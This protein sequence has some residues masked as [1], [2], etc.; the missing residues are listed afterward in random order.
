MAPIAFRELAGEYVSHVQG[1][2][3]TG[4]MKMWLKRLLPRSIWSTMRAARHAATRLARQSIESLGFRLARRSDFYSPLPSEFELKKFAHRWNKP[5]AMAGIN[6]DLEAMRQLLSALMSQYAHEFSRLPSYG[7]ME[8]LKFG[9]GYPQVDALV[10]YAMIRSFKPKRY[11]EVGSGLSTYYAGRAAE[12]NSEDGHRTQITCIEPFP[13][14]SLY[15]IADIKIVKGLVQDVA[16]DVF[17]ELEA[18]DLLFIDSSHSVRIDGDVPFL[19]LEVLPVLNQG[20]HIHIHDIP[21]PFNTPYP[22]AYWVFG[23]D[24]SSPHW[25]MYWTE[26]MLV[27]ALLAFSSRFKID[28]SCPM[29]RHYDEAFFRRTV[30]VY[31][32]ITEEPNTFSSL[33]LTRS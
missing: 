12:K 24:K 9:P 2:C 25:P 11:L 7:D 26:A 16:L 29:L 14:D 17:T 28:L 15:K 5:S 33:W 30:P 32:P 6:Y 8:Q 22:A 20:V 18:G 31:R 1:W 4:C 23:E 13:F 21:F 3:R 10:L 27:Q 19:C